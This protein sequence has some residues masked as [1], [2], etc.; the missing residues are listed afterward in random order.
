MNLVNQFPLYFVTDSSLPLPQ[1]LHVIEE[2]VKGGV[3]VVQLREKQLNGLKFYEKAK[4]LKKLLTSYDI[5]LIINDRIDIALSVEADGVHIG[6]EDIPLDMVK[7]IVP[8]TMIVGVSA[9]TFTEAQKAEKGGADYIGVGAMF[10]TKTKADSEVA[11][12]AELVKI[13]NEIKIPKVAIGGIKEENI[14]KIREY[15]FDGI[16]V[17]SAISKS[18][19]PYEQSENL[20][21]KF[22]KNL[23]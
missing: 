1:L 5:P 17:I 10:P 7:K 13:A 4:V 3:G 2:A 14:A 8:S 19:N 20:L 22:R 12:K 11:A 6:Q 9:K 23:M 16:A 18:E 21:R 15:R